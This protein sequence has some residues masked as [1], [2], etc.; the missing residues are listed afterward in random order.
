MFECVCVCVCVFVSASSVSVTALGRERCLSGVRDDL[1]SSVDVL[2]CA[3]GVQGLCQRLRA[4][5]SSSWQEMAGVVFVFCSSR[6][7]ENASTH[8]VQQY[9]T[10]EES[11]AP[12]LTE[13]SDGE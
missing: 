8:L 12:Q 10:V 3:E 1:M 13:I 6:R 7:H 11:T 2:G 9:R 4:T 5:S